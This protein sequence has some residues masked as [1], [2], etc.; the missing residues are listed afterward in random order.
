MGFRLPLN[1]LPHNEKLFYEE[2]PLV[3]HRPAQLENFYEKVS[4]RHQAFIKNEKK[5][6]MGL[7]AS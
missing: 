7:I 1:S 4:K 3:L 2:E 6:Q 5:P